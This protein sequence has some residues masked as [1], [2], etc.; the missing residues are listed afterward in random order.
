MTINADQAVAAATERAAAILEAA[1]VEPHVVLVIRSSMSQ[2]EATTF[3]ASQEEERARRA[4]EIAQAEPQPTK[5]DHTAVLR[6]LMAS[7]V[8][9]SAAVEGEPSAITKGTVNEEGG[10]AR[11]AAEAAGVEPPA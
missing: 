1:G 5:E 8:D 3:I 6:S 11:L 9:V 2:S 10:L 4:R 7:D